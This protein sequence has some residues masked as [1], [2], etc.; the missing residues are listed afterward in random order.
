MAARAA[1]TML[2][3]GVEECPLNARIAKRAAGLV[4]GE[5]RGARVQRTG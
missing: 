2:S 4:K 3:Q 1:T 5:N